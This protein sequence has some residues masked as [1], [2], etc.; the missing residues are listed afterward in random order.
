MPPGPAADAAPGRHP[1]GAAPGPGAPGHAKPAAPAAAWCRAY[2]QNLL[3]LVDALTESVLC[4]LR[5]AMREAGA[6]PAQV[7]RVFGFAEHPVIASC[8]EQK[9]G[10]AVFGAC[11]VLLNA[12]GCL[13]P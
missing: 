4:N 2:E 11:E 3:G 6:G 5:L 12:A 7:E 10:R 9:Y 13:K 8:V 1:R